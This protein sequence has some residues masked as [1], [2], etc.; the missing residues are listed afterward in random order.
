MRI[1]LLTSGR[2]TLLDIARE[3]SAFG[4]DVKLYSLLP[5]FQTQRF[6]LPDHCNRWLGLGSYPY[7][8]GVRYLPEGALKDV[9]ST[10]MLEA[11]DDSACAKLEPCDVLI[12]MSGIGVRALDE[13][14]R[15][16]G[17]RI[18]VERSSVH[19][20]SQ[21]AIMQRM[22]GVPQSYSANFRYERELLSYALSDVITVPSHHVYQSFIEQ[23]HA[24]EQLFKNPFGVSLDQFAPTRAPGKEGR[25][26]I[27]M[28]GA[29]SLRKG[30]DV[31]VQ[32]WRKLPGTRLLHVGPLAGAPLPDDPLFEHVDAVPQS[33]LPKFYAQGHVF[34]LASREEGLAT[35]QVQALACGLPVVC[36]TMT[37]GFDLKPWTS[38]EDAVRV[39]PPDD[40]E[41][42]RAALEQALATSAPAGELR[43]LLGI[44]RKELSWTASA[45]RYE[46]R[47][48]RALDEP[49]RVK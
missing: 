12:A 41:A 48:L 24:P 38:T 5:T 32:A 19:I 44:H 30:C 31:L 23:G 20:L 29:W 26:T 39:V 1:A 28:T 22:P 6:G 17:A 15:R 37:G 8:A 27:L 10:R 35:V 18:F 40:P 3:L 14:R 34:A 7:Y 16:Y 47:L 21:R 33:E 25:P 42:L 43:D 45:R 46:Q 13:A 9:I 4:H 11:I 49:P 2:F 36:T